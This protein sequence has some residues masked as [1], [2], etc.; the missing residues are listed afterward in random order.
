MLVLGLGIVLIGA[1]WLVASLGLID[2]CDAANKPEVVCNT[3][4][5]PLILLQLAVGIAGS[6]LAFL[7]G[8][9]MVWAAVRARFSHR[10]KPMTKAR[11]VMAGLWTVIYLIGLALV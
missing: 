9:L 4:P 5:R 3:P 8:G 11:T 10:L 7:T 1:F 6:A 2:P